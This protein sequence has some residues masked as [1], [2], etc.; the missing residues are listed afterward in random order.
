MS[1]N[2]L[3]R[4]DK[5]LIREIDEELYV[6]EGDKNKLFARE[7]LMPV[8]F[9]RTTWT[10]ILHD[11]PCLGATEEGKSFTYINGPLTNKSEAEAV[12][13]QEK[14]DTNEIGYKFSS[15]IKTI[16]VSPNKYPP[17]FEKFIGESYP[18]TATKGS[19][20]YDY[21]VG[22]NRFASKKEHSGVYEALPGFYEPVTKDLEK[23]S[24]KCKW[25]P[26][27]F[28]KRK[29]LLSIIDNTF[30]EAGFSEAT[31]N[32]HRVFYIGLLY[33]EPKSESD[34]KK[35]KAR[36]VLFGIL[37]KHKVPRSACSTVRDSEHF[38]QPPVPELNL[39]YNSIREFIEKNNFIDI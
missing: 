6:S 19:G 35:N 9:V 15:N 12:V 3:I 22:D 39:K 17:K 20:M 21:T 7:K 23:A 14:E 13:K 2:P 24:E 25:V 36:H 31:F 4:L 18:I 26:K 37:D 29:N 33:K 5:K 38:I 32:F 27:E 28:S 11:S 16:L 8:Y 10:E 30:I 1:E 34:K